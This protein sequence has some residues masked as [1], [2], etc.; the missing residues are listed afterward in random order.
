M[1]VVTLGPKAKY[2]CFHSCCHWALMQ[3]ILSL[4]SGARASSL[5][6]PGLFAASPGPSPQHVNTPEKLDASTTAT[7]RLL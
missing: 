6:V 4:G 2:Q 1:I 5:P 3:M 7:F